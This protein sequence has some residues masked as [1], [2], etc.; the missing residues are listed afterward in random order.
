MGRANEVMNT[1]SSTF[2]ARQVAFSRNHFDPI[3]LIWHLICAA[4]LGLQFQVG[5][6]RPRASG[7]WTAGLKPQSELD[8]QH[9]LRRN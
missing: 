1:R 7:Q 8:G 4:P 5:G 6:L 3:Q 9:A 2:A